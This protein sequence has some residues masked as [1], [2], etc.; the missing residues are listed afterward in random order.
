MP[1]PKEE[2]EDEMPKRA[3][4]TSLDEQSRVED[5]SEEDMLTKALTFST[6]EKFITQIYFTRYICT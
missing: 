2:N 6:E 1:T 3:T 4:I 5:E